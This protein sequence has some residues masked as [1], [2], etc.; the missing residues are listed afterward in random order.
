MS[1][2]LLTLQSPD[3]TQG[4]VETVETQFVVGT[5]T[6]PDV[7][8]VTGAGVAARHAWVWI[9]EAGLQVDPLG[10]ETFVNGHAISERV[11]AEYPASVQVG[12]V[13]LVV[14]R[15]SARLAAAFAE[16]IPIACAQPAEP[17][18]PGNDLAITIPAKAAKNLKPQPPAEDPALAETIPATK[19]GATQHARQ[20]SVTANFNK[21]PV[22]RIAPVKKK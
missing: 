17:D 1:T 21:A 10:G 5:E 3:G 18:R 11:Q 6:A 2:W 7:Y 16:T 20:V 19:S 4:S 12:E 14:E 22:N 8:K 9:G 15:Q 13:T